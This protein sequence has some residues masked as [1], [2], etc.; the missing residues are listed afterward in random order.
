MFGVATPSKPQIDVPYPYNNEV[1][2]MYGLY[3]AE[4]FAHAQTVCTFFSA[5]AQKPATMH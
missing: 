1:I 4:L 2:N 3:T 5:H